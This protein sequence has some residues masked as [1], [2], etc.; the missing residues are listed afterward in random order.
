MRRFSVFAVLWVVFALV[1]PNTSAATITLREKVVVDGPRFTLADV[2]TV[3]DADAELAARM[4]AVDLGPA[5][6]PGSFMRVD[7]IVVRLKL[8]QAR[9]DPRDVQVDA[10]AGCEVTTRGLDIPSARLVELAREHLSSKI[11]WS[12][13]DVEI[14]VTGQPNDYVVPLGCGEDVLRPGRIN[15]DNPRGRVDVGVRIVVDGRDRFNASVRFN[16]KLYEEVVVTTDGLD[17]GDTYTADN[18]EL[19]RMDVTD[20]TP[21]LLTDLDKVLGLKSARRIAQNTPLTRKMVISPP[22]VKRGDIVRIVYRVKG[23]EVSA[24]GQARADGAEGD[25]ILVKN[26]DSGRLLPAMVI[27]SGTV[28]VGG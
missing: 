16:V 4:E 2:A 1:I 21:G 6:W 22:L 14:E 10:A 8:Y 7:G 11:R 17:R 5:P 18:V 9:I 25:T 20:A 26:V 24:S 28:L 12:P 15:S 13:D 27:S 23:L 19:R 3:A